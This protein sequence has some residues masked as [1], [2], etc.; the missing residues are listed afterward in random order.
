MHVV[1]MVHE[2]PNIGEPRG[3]K[4]VRFV[5]VAI[6]LPNMGRIIKERKKKNAERLEVKSDSPDGSRQHIGDGQKGISQTS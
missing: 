5:T 4:S 1:I 2:M 6:C 3:T